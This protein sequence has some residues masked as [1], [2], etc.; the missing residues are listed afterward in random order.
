MTP[1]TTL[2]LAALLGLTSAGLDPALVHTPW[3][4]LGSA[5]RLGHPMFLATLSLVLVLAAVPLE[6]RVG[7][8]ALMASWGLPC[9]A[10][11]W[12]YGRAWPELAGLSLLVTLL[13]VA[14]RRK[15]PLP[16]KV[17]LPLWGVM[18][19]TLW[20]LSPPPGAVAIS[21]GMAV[22]LGWFSRGEAVAVLGLASAGALLLAWLS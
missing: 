12:L 10:Q 19:L 9:L 4:G 1:W 21:V 6:L 22:G 15:E 8:L 18:G 3:S 14:Y 20:I 13:V 11:F 2:A 16:W 5:F 7:R 17:W